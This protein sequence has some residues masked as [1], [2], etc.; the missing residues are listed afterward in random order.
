M[1]MSENSEPRE[2][3]PP[4][5]LLGSAKDRDG[6]RTPVKFFGPKDAT[7][8]KPAKRQVRSAKKAAKTS[9]TQSAPTAEESAQ[10]PTTRPAPRPTQIPESDSSK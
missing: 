9:S 7:A 5:Q 2:V 8:P 4:V 10:K 3:N 6:D 1:Q